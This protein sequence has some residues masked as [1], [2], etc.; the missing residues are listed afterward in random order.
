MK[1]GR[2]RKCGTGN[3]TVRTAQLENAATGTGTTWIKF[4]PNFYGKQNLLAEL[5]NKVD[6]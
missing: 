4:M 1:A 5:T 3:A 2:T 6:V